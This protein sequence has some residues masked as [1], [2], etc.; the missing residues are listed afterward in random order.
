MPVP[1]RLAR[2]EKM[3]RGP[4][5]KSGMVADTAL[6]PGKKYKEHFEIY[7]PVQEKLV[8]GKTQRSLAT[9]KLKV[10]VKLR[11]QPFGPKEKGVFIWRDYEKTVPVTAEGL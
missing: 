3:G 7:Y 8:D 4:Y 1:Q 6:H 11:Y 2:G 9:D 10:Q 5:E